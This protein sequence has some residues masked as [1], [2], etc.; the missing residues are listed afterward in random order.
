[1]PKYKEKPFWERNINPITG[2]LVEKS[3]GKIGKDKLRVKRRILK[4]LE[5]YGTSK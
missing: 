1:M 4:S 5:T 2:W 3:D